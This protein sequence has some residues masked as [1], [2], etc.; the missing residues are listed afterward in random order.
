MKRVLL[1]GALFFV[2]AFSCV[3]CLSGASESVTPANNVACDTI[4]NVDSSENNIVEEEHNKS[5]MFEK[6]NVREHCFIV[7]SKKDL[8]LSVYEARKQDTV[9]VARFDCCLGRNKGNK[10]KRGD[11]K[12]PECTMQN[13]FKIVS[14]EKSSDWMHDFGDGRG[15]IL[16]YGNWFLRL[17]TGFNGIGIHGST[18]NESSV[19]GR[20]SEGCVRLRNSEI[21]SLKQNYAFVGM[22]VIVKGEEEGF[23]PFER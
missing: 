16:A 14:I 1:F 9:I 5:L 22:K 10:E 4:K 20:Y 12:T 21:D 19:P 23:L 15:R 3:M 8:T 18:N 13:P 2:L 6:M 7:V 17:H 11:M